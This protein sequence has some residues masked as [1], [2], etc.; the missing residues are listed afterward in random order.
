MLESVSIGWMLLCWEGF[1]AD[2][3]CCAGE[4]L[5]RVNAAA[6]EDLD[7]LDAAVLRKA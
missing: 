2:G 7:W 3:C 4:G 5:D 6:G 1:V